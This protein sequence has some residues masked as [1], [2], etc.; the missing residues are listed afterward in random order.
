MWSSL[1]CERSDREAHISSQQIFGDFG[2]IIDHWV[3]VISQISRSRTLAKIN[4]IFIVH[5]L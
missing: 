3:K 1:S 2:Q 5:T 4:T